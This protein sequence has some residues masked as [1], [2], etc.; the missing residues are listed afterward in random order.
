MK[1]WT[2]E[3]AF[4]YPHNRFLVGWEYIEK[5]KKYK[6]TTIRLYLFIATITIDF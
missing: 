6:Y 2:L 4:H 5:D 3:I 1:E